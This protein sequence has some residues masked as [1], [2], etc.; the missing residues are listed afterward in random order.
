MRAHVF[1]CGCRWRAKNSSS[2]VPF[3]ILV[4]ETFAVVVTKSKPTSRFALLLSRTLMQLSRRV[5][6]G[7]PP[8]YVPCFPT[9][10]ITR[11]QHRPSLMEPWT[12]TMPFANAAGLMSSFRGTM[13]RNCAASYQMIPSRSRFNWRRPK[14]SLRKAS[15][16]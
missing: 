15:S 3:I 13:A 11:L 4:R 8:K 2:T 5:Q 10:S 14:S 7:N 6:P 1:L 9:S 12:V 16:N